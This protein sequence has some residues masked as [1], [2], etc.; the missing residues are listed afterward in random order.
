MSDKDQRHGERGAAGIKFLIIVTI[1]LLVAHAG[2]NYVPVAYNA[3]SFKQDMQTAVTQ[4][5]AMPNLG[6]GNPSENLKSRIKRAA[7][8]NEIPENLWMDVQPSKSGLQAR[9][10]FTQNVSILPFGLYTYKYYFDHTATP[11]GFLT[12]E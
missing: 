9:V 3:E 8:S 12:K 7:A 1:L 6:G 5:T 2:F 10:V 4:V 11:V